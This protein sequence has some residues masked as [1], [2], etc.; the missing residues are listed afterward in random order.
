MQCGHHGMQNLNAFIYLYNLQ[1][2]IIN[3]LHKNLRSGEFASILRMGKAILLAILLGSSQITLGQKILSK[4]DSIKSKKEVENLIH[5][6]NERYK[7]FAITEKSLSTQPFSKGDFDKNGLTDLLAIGGFP[8]YFIGSDTIK[9]EFDDRIFVVMNFGK[10]SLKIKSLTKG[11]GHN[12]NLAFPKI[13][14][15]TIITI[16]QRNLIFKFGDFIELN[17]NPKN[18]EIE[19]IEYQTTH[20]YG[21]CPVFSIEINKDKTGLFEASDYN[22]E[23]GISIVD[24]HRKKNNSKEI[25]GTFRA[26]IKDDS[27]S[28]IINLVN[29]MDFP[30]LKDN[31]SVNWTDDQT[32]ILKI[33]YNNGQTKEVRDYGLIGNYG[34]ARLYQLFFEMRFNQIW[35]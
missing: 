17:P 34:L 13:V 22:S 31:Y 16:E 25:K 1:L 26:I 19:K 7:E 28:E 4:I 14:N 15:D 27:F 5:S 10:D 12:H 9:R 35:K 18:Y 23:T 30:T 20:C 29:Y 3:F 2:E 11:M 24:L 8:V 32:C 33:T 6:L 21:T